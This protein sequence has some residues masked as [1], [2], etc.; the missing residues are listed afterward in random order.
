MHT[1]HMR[2]R[3]AAGMS[4]VEL[5]VS[6]TI[7]VMLMTGLVAVFNSSGEARREL[8]KSG[9]LIENGRYAVSLLF[10][11]LHHA[12]FYGHFY[13]LGDAL[14]ALPDPCEV[15]GT[16]NTDDLEAATAMP[17][18]GYA[19]ADIDSLPDI[20]STTTCETALLTD[21]NLKLGSDIV[22][23][24]RADTAVF[25]GAAEAKDIYLQANS[26]AMNLLVGNASATVPA[27]AA[28]NATQTMEKYP[29][30]GSQCSSD[31]DKC[32]DTRKYRVHVYFVA[33]CSFGTG[34]NNV[35][36][37]GD[38]EVPTLKR[39]ELGSDGTST[40]MEIMPLVE[41]VEYMKVEYGIDTTPTDVNG[42]TGLA[43]DGVPDEYKDEPAV[44]EW[45]LVVS[46]RIYILARN[47]TGT[48]EYSDAKTYQ[49]GAMSA[50]PFEDTF[51]RRLFH[52]EVR[53]MNLAG[54]REIPK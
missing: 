33:P 23:I 45:P 15:A 19:A 48:V 52:T 53:P 49:L 30:K 12:G 43:G 44:G 18:Q 41:G 27:K 2:L 50:G 37:D 29:D 6:I 34:A 35:C 32:A 10:E 24:R 31:T 17:I 36:Q 13:R 38:D 14:A 46:V 3:S 7:G 51:K 5:M 4:L 20:D 16:G 26:R 40:L 42:A 22:I 47:V 39:L 25:T 1:R 21:A 28:N 11:D 9:Q 8:E 54:R